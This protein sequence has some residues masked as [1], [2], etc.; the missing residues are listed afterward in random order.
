MIPVRV[1]LKNFLCYAEADNGQPIEFDFEGSPLWSISGDNG[2][3]KSAIFDAIT[4]TLFGEHR[5]GA[6]GD[7]RLIR[8]GADRCEVVFEF[9]LDGQLYRVRRTV[10]RAKGRG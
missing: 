5:G 10:G 2:A 7:S 1:L 4:Y 8:K 3:G 6:V 9:R